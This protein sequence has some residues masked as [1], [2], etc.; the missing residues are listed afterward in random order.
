[1]VFATNFSFLFDEVSTFC[2]LLMQR[3]VEEY[4]FLDVQSKT[5]YQYGLNHIIF[6]R[7]VENF[8]ILNKFL[9][10]EVLIGNDNILSMLQLCLNDYYEIRAIW[11]C[12]SDLNQNVPYFWVTETLT[13]LPAWFTKFENRAL[14]FFL[15]ANKTSVHS[16]PQKIIYA[17][18]RWWATVNY[19]IAEKCDLTK[20]GVLSR[21]EKNIAELQRK[22]RLSFCILIQTKDIGGRATAEI[23]EEKVVLCTWS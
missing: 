19:S 22:L 13:K 23:S 8:I 10:P 11:S 7:F 14:K 5:C 2:R 9:T 18:L 15:I 3:A 1:M 6:I 20:H 21:T 17:K 16:S 12:C 4:C